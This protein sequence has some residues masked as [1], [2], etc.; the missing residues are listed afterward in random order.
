[1]LREKKHVTYLLA[2]RYA[3]I[4]FYIYT[5]FLM[6]MKQVQYH[7]AQLT[8]PYNGQSLEE[9]FSNLAEN[10]LQVKYSSSTIPSAMKKL[11]TKTPW[12]SAED[13]LEIVFEKPS[14]EVSSLM[15]LADQLG[16]PVTSHYP[17]SRAL[18]SISG[19]G[20][21][22]HGRDYSLEQALKT[23][24]EVAKLDAKKAGATVDY[25]LDSEVVM[26]RPSPL[27]LRKQPYEKTSFHVTAEHS[28]EAVI[29]TYKRVLGLSKHF[30]IDKKS[31]KSSI[32]F[33]ND[34]P[35]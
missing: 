16:A 9:S 13:S 10:D 30:P 25:D 29:E 17:I 5:D 31:V 26:H 35:L 34:F 19:V 32:S 23:Q 7:F 33:H 28:V 8:R 4:L 6:D 20:Y 1:M 2:S 14:L 11:V 3:Q 22:E 27:V 18:A 21:V 15:D 12:S 24:F